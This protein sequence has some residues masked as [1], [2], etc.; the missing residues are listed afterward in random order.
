MKPE[1]IIENRKIRWLV[2]FGV[3]TFLG[4]FESTRLYAVYNPVEKLIPWDRAFVWGLTYWYIW[5]ALSP[6]IYWLVRRFPFE[7]GGMWS[8]LSIHIVASLIFAMIQ[9]AINAQA[10]LWQEGLVYL[11]QTSGTVTYWVVFKG[12]LTAKFHPAALVYWGVVFV[13]MGLDYYRRYKEERLRASEI[14]ARLAQAELSALRM[15]LQPHFLFNTLNT[16]AALMREDVDLADRMLVRLS[17]LLRIVLERHGGAEVSLK[18]ELDFV[19][20]YLEIERI[21]FQD[22]LTVVYDIAPDTLEAKA[23][24]LIL[25]PLVENAIKHGIAPLEQGGSIKV[26]SERVNE[27]LVITVSDTGPGFA[28][29]WNERSAMRVGLSNTRERL[30]QMYGDRQLFEVIGD[31][32]DGARVRLV[33]PFHTGDPQ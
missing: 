3:W 15:Q 14:E 16:I 30:K 6:V 32:A 13:Y 26:T 33:I 27:T 18:E 1:P 7:R 29:G 9:L 2:I 24:N 25:Q 10:L 11:Y 19:E 31:D 12:S 4:V 21:R 17:E 22:R 20:R 23:P 5:A 8:A 28:D